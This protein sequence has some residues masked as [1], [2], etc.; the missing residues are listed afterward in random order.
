M[1][2]WWVIAEV[3]AVAEGIAANDGN[4]AVDMGH[5]CG[6]N[7]DVGCV[8]ILCECGSGIVFENDGIRL[9]FGVR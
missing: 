4:C 5:E 7:T 2:E 8:L 3:A 1:W 9:G 6:V